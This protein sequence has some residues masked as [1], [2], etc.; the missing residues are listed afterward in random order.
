[1]ESGLIQ[2]LQEKVEGLKCNSKGAE[3]FVCTQ[4]SGSIVKHF[5]KT[6]GILLL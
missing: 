4:G 5:L 3:N 1:M 6:A 2:S